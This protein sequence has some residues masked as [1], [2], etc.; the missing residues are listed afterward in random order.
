VRE[1]LVQ[2]RGNAVAAKIIRFETEPGKQ[3]QVDWGQMRGGKTPIHAFVAVLGFSRALFVH[4]TDNMRYETLEERHRLAFEY[5]QGIPADVWY[6][7]MKTVVLERNAYGAGQH[8][9]HP[10]FYQFAKSMGFIPKLC[11]NHIQTLSINLDIDR[12]APG[13]DEEKTRE[14]INQLFRIDY[15]RKKKSIDI[16]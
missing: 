11:K 7:N 10:S 1:H 2:L 6:D 15:F 4:Y 3:M 13:F 9:F 16:M 14:L 5:F 12:K 8:R